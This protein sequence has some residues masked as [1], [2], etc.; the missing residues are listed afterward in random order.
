MAETG[1]PGPQTRPWLRVRRHTV[2]LLPPTGGAS[3]RIWAVGLGEESPIS[4]PQ[5][6]LGPV[7]TVGQA[8]AAARGHAARF[9]TGPAEPPNALG[10]PAPGSTV[11]GREAAKAGC[12]RPAPTSARRRAGWVCC[13]SFS[14]PVVSTSAVPRTA[15]QQASPSVTTPRSLLEL[16]SIELGMPPHHLILCPLLLL[17]SGFSVGVGVG[18]PNRSSGLCS[19]AKPQ[20][21]NPSAITEMGD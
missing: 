19:H 7:S 16:I 14:R 10:L 6:E 8:W 11:S 15:A 2:P 17:P 20:I 4:F 12:F 5:A 1:A 21:W 9:P 3:E 13:S 18:E